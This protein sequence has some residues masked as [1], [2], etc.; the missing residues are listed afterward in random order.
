MATSVEQRDE[1]ASPRLAPGGRSTS[2]NQL[3]ANEGHG[4]AGQVLGRSS[5]NPPVTGGRTGLFGTEL[6]GMGR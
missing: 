2:E 1:L 5:E 6:K 4:T 3:S